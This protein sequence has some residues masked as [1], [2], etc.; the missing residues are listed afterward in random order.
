MV[1]I[2]LHRSNIIAS[3]STDVIKFSFYV[4]NYRTCKKLFMTINASK[5]LDKD[6]EDKKGRV[7]RQE[8]YSGAC[9][10]SFY[11]GNVKPEDVRAK[12]DCGVL[13]VIVPKEDMKKLSSSSAVTI[14]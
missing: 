14:E 2:S 6:E 10:R 12:Y 1:F 3:K 8:R 4:V 11:I 9:S 5:G 13:T 7:L